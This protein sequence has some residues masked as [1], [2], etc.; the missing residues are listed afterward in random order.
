[1]LRVSLKIIAIITFTFLNF[2]FAHSQENKIAKVKFELTDFKKPSYWANIFGL[3]KFSANNKFLALSSE[4]RD[5]DIYE[6][7]SGKLKSKLGVNSKQ[8]FNAFSFSPDGK[9]ALMQQ[10]VT[11]N[12]MLFDLETG[13]LIREIIPT[14]KTD[15]GNFAFPD[16]GGLQMANASV[17]NDWKNAV[18]AINPA[19]YE[20]FGFESGKLKFRLNHAEKQSK[21]KD[22]MKAVGVALFK[23]VGW[24]SNGRVEFSPNNTLV[25][26]TSGND[27][28]TLWETETGKLIAKLEPQTNRVYLSVFAPD[29][30][31]ILTFNNDGIFST[32]EATTGKLISSFDIKEKNA[33]PKAINLE[34]QRVVTKNVLRKNKDAKIWD[35]K[36]GKQLAVL[37]KCDPSHLVFSPDGKTLASIPFKQKQLAQLWDSATGKLLASLP[38]KNEENSLAILWTPDSKFLIT[39]SKD[40]VKIWNQKGELQQILENAKYPIA[41]SEDGRLLATGG[42]KNSGYVWELNK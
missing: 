38:R 19:Q 18:I 30:Q 39:A 16:E 17:S 23:G 35:I 29:N 10:I 24:F 37:E 31:F 20:L 33:F 7:E 12:L 8:G 11:Q 13:N 21:F 42:N 22:R 36:S 34:T 9:T 5:I 28:P 15:G 14:E 27:S 3:L 32:W 1:M 4:E 26:I 2:T 41:L 40:N 6:V 25:V